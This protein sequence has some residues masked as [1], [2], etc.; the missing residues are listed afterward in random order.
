[1]CYNGEI[2]RIDSEVVIE[3]YKIAIESNQDMLDNLQ[4]NQFSMGG[5]FPAGEGEDISQD[6][7]VI[8]VKDLSEILENVDLINKNDGKQLF[9]VNFWMTSI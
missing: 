2:Y 8:E 7:W 9:E 3:E 1:M 5:I 6:A 4:N